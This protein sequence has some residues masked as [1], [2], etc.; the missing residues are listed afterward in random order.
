M[1]AARAAWRADG[2]GSLRILRG[3]KPGG[4]LPQISVGF[5]TCMELVSDMYSIV[6]WHAIDQGEPISFSIVS[7]LKISSGWVGACYIE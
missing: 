7:L 1:V 3:M 2:D 6:G 5:P 4:A